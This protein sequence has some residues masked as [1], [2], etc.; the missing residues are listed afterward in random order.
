MLTAIMKNQGAEYCFYSGNILI[1][2]IYTCLHV[3]WIISTKINMNL[4]LVISS[5]EEDVVSTDKDWDEYLLFL[6]YGF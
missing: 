2:R 6:L 4:V 1:P 3:K 5:W